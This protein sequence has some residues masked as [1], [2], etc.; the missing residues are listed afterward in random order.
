MLRFAH[1][2]GELNIQQSH[3]GEHGQFEWFY[4]VDGLGYRYAFPLSDTFEGKNIDFKKY[5]YYDAIVNT[6]L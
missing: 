4:G 2:H 5:M 3:D 6:P 1:A